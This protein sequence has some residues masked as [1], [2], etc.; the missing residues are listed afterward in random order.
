MRVNRQEL[1]KE[2]KTSL[3]TVD[4]WV[5]EG[6]PFV[7]RGEK[8]KSWVFETAD[9]QEWLRRREIEKAR[10]RA[11]REMPDDLDEL[12]AR[13]LAAETALV[14]LELEQA[15]G[16]VAPVDQVERMACKAFATVR[17]AMRNIPGRV[18]S[19]LIGETD[20]RA[21]K[22]TLLAEIDEA[23]LALST[24]AL[25]SPEDDDDEEAEGD[26]DEDPDDAD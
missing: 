10:A 18:V 3:P 19:Q 14:E 7:V 17:A 5:R 6:M 9:C 2:M 15:R 25:L 12:K 1:A 16:G 21:F 23:L 22:E 8:G 24:A 11:E 20:E 26:E 4:K 13:K